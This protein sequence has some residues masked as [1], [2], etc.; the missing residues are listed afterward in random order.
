MQRDVLDLAE[1][2]VVVHEPVGFDDHRPVVPAVRDE[3]LPAGPADRLVEV[4][5]IGRVEGERLLAHHVRAGFEGC[6][7]L[8]VMEPGRAADDDD[9]G[10]LGDDL[11]P[12]SG[13][14]RE[15]VTLGDPVEER[16]VAAVDD[17]EVDLVA[18]PL[19]VRKMRADGPGA[20]T[21]DAQSK[22]RHSGPPGQWKRVRPC[23]RAR[24]GAA[25]TAAHRD[26]KSGG[27]WRHGS[28]RWTPLR[29]ESSGRTGVQLTQLGLGGAPIGSMAVRVSEEDS[30]ATVRQAW[31]EGVRYF[32]TAPWYGRGL[33]E[34]R[35][36]AGLRD[37]PRDEFI[38]SSKVGRWLKSPADRQ[39]FDTSP[40]VGGNPFAIVFDYTYDGIMRSYEQ[41]LQRLGVATYDLA[42]IHDLD[43]WHHASE[44]KVAAYE[45]QLM[46]SGWRALDELKRAGLIRAI[47]AGINER[48]ML[49]RWM[50]RVDLDFFLVALPYTLLDQDVLDAEFPRLAEL[51]MGVVIGAV[52]ASGILA[53]GP[54]DDARYAYAPASEAVKE[55]TRRL[56]EVCGRHGVPLAGRGPAV[57]AWASV[58]CGRHTG[59]VHRGPGLAERGDIPPGHPGR[60]VGRAQAR[61]LD[62]CRG[63][64]PCLIPRTGMSSRR[65]PTAWRSIGV[66]DGWSR[67]VTGRGHGPS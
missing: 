41:S 56:A 46:A 40:W 9:I 8:L 47:G 58:R 7:G 43:F 27:A 67:C 30:L 16:R 18:M 29:R 55:K 3:E 49:D 57:P 22:L 61:R 53:T 48:Q 62:P 28:E 50:D 12:V 6:L 35:M 34:L 31:T 36:G 66:R 5:G 21:D 1:A 54:I 65:P 39:T 60:P 13:P 63:A 32:D 42:V 4:P 2:A 17:R 64:R 59:G 10:A 45:A 15:A 37:L 24:A 25:A 44:P 26:L 23:Y 33:S 11:V 51:G 20:G 52:F 14:L 19:E 38:L